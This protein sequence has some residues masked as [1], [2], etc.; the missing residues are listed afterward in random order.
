MGQVMSNLIGNAIQYSDRSG[1]VTVAIAGTDAATL[2]MGVHDPGPPI[3][4]EAQKTFFQ[5]WMRGQVQ[6][7]AEHPHL[8]L[9]LYIAK[10][11]VHGGEIA[12]RSEKPTG[13]TFTVRLPRA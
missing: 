11:I 9:G 6:D 4:A 1:P 8:G 10:L 12:V 13:T 5:S 3:P 7:A 2:G